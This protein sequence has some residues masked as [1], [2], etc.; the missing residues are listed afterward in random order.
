MG[1]IVASDS[2]LRDFL[3][4]WAAGVDWSSTEEKKTFQKLPKV[5][6]DNSKIE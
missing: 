1:D 4:F 6:Q 2:D 3:I 5:Y